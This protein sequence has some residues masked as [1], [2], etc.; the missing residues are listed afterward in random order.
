MNAYIATYDANARK[1]QVGV[2]KIG[3]L[4]GVL[5]N[6]VPRTFRAKIRDLGGFRAVDADQLVEVLRFP[7]KNAR[8]FFSTVSGLNLINKRIAS[9][10]EL[11]HIAFD[12][13][14]VRAIADNGRRVNG[15]EHD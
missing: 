4:S 8:R 5:E 7:S 11:S 9:D 10:A 15:V 12:E 2:P 14:A 13:V 3:V 1:L 6:V